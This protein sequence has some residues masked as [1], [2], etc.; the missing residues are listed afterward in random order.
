MTFGQFCA[1]WPCSPKRKGAKNSR[2]HPF[3]DGYKIFA[4]IPERPGR[5]LIDKLAFCNEVGHK[6]DLNGRDSSPKVIGQNLFQFFE[7]DAFKT[8]NA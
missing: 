1:P 2:P 5:G 4:Q 8:I 3:D 6:L 7:S